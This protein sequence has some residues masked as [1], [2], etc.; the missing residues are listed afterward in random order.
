MKKF[1]IGFLC[2]FV[3]D[4]HSQVLRVID[5]TDLRPLEGVMLLDNLN[6]MA[7]T[8][9]R[10]R[11]SVDIFKNSELITFSHLGYNAVAAS[12]KQLQDSAFVLHLTPNKIS[13]DEAVVR[14]KRW[15]QYN[16]VVSNK[17]V[18]LGRKEIELQNPQTAAD[19]LGFS[20]QVFVQKSQ[21]GGGSPMIRG[22]STNRLL[23]SV[24]G[25]RMNTAIFR[26]GNLQNIISIDPNVV[27]T[28]EVIFGPGSVIYGSDA[29]GGVMSFYTT[30]PSFSLENEMAVDGNALTR[31]SSANSEMTGHFDI[32][33]GWKKW[34]AVTSFTYSDFDDLK[35]GS[36]G[37]DDYLVPYYVQRVD[38]QDVVVTNPDPQ[39]Q[40]P[41]G[42]SQYNLMQKI[43]FKPNNAWD[44]NYAYHYSTTSNYGRFDRHRRVRNGKPRYGEWYYGPQVWAMHNVGISHA[45]KTKFF[46]NV[47]LQLAYQHFEESRNSRNFNS[48]DLEMNEEQVDAYSANL[49]FEKGAETKNR[50]FYGVEY[51]FNKVHSTGMSKNIDTE[52]MTPIATRYP[53]GST[54]AS[55]AAY[56]SYEYA[57]SSLFSL[58]AGLRY[59]GFALRASFDDAINPMPFEDADINTGA[60]SGSLGAVYHASSSMKVRAN[61]STG[62]RAPNIDDIGKLYESVDGAV[63][64]PNPDLASEYAYNFEVG[65]AKIFGKRLKIDLTAFYTILD[66]AQLR[67][68]YTINGMDSMMYEGELSQLLAIQNAARATVY[69]LQMGLDLNMGGGFGLSS[70]YNIQHGE[71]KLVGGGTDPMR[72][73]APAFGATHITFTQHKLM[74]DWYIKYSAEVSNEDLASSEQGKTEIYAKDQNGNPY[75]PSWYTFNFKAVY[76]L[77]DMLNLTA[78]IENITDQRYLPYSSGIVAPGRNMVIGVRAQF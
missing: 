27:E 60:L 76:Q 8:D 47:N 75:S 19:L 52:D 3:F 13:L 63:V 72:H 57:P 77:T 14:S 59:N 55:Y 46:D 33:L 4:A 49:D 37:P 28:S 69:G 78:G 7:L 74:L 22:F 70:F 42:Y 66:D 30:E 40:V 71:E 9:A 34:A 10:G 18:A 35:M 67:Q 2:L 54:W 21:L 17:V 25:V 1:I 16:V 65:I 73:A 36:F 24:D 68:P 61:I 26:S 45:E 64:V 5:H 53:D 20:D 31:Y 12:Y 58:Q 50:F 48:P 39:V 6:N 62:F 15:D 44:F 38:T 32:N 29:I 11:V 43:R 51:I 41:T 23:I 56:M